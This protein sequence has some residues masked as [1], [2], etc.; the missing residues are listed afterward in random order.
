MTAPGENRENEQNKIYQR[1]YHH[2]INAAKKRMAADRDY[3]EETFVIRF[4]FTTR[5]CELSLP[6]N[7]LHP[8]DTSDYLSPCFYMPEA[9]LRRFV[10]E[11]E[12]GYS[13]TF[14]QL[15]AQEMSNRCQEETFKIIDKQV[16][17]F[18]ELAAAAIARTFPPN[19]DAEGKGLSRERL[20]STIVA[21]LNGSAC[22]V[23]QA[24][25][26]LINKDKQITARNRRLLYRFLTEDLRKSSVLALFYPKARS[27]LEQLALASF[28]KGENEEIVA[29]IEAAP[30]VQLSEDEEK[31][32]IEAIRSID[33]ALKNFSFHMHL[34]GLEM[35]E[36]EKTE[37][38][39]PPGLRLKDILGGPSGAI[40]TAIEKIYEK[41]RGEDN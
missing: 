40:A 23:F 30:A 16:D 2:L 8:E 34:Y 10:E 35:P 39:E 1:C 37:R 20:K 12:P 36:E 22:E 33:E 4:N 18:S 24:L 25:C 14:L 41:E 26:S 28:G 31:E 32:I 3:P 17:D 15:L 38:R 9:D 7:V 29:Q 27:L 5:V 11:I 21:I 6:W 13:E 19:L